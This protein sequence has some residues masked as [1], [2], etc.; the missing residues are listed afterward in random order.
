[1]LHNPETYPDP[2]TFKPER[3]EGL[4]K[5]ELEKV[6]PRGVVFG[7]GRRYVNSPPFFHFL[8]LSSFT[9]ITRI[10]TCRK[11]P[12]EQLAE[13]SAFLLMSYI[14]ATM[15]ISPFADPKTGEE[16]LPSGEFHSGFVL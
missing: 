10:R 5:E 3:F 4:T 11:C 12:G 14:V 9:H 13:A 15:D 7:F 8:S 6:D 2:D 16:V 1:M